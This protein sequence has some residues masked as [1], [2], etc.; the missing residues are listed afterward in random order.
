MGYLGG[1]NFALLVT[2]V[3]ILYPNACAS[4]IIAKFFRIYCLWSWTMPIRLTDVKTGGS[5]SQMVWD[6]AQNRRDALALFPIITPC[7]PASN[8]TYN[9][10]VR[11]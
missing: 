4:V 2:Y 9:V 7:Y 6:P 5:M 1:V 3:C 11:C 8:S 10:S